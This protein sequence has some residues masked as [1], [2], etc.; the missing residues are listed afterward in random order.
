MTNINHNKYEDLMQDEYD[1]DDDDEG[2]EGE[3]HLKS[4]KDEPDE[5]REDDAKPKEEDVSKEA[6]GIHKRDASRG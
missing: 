5:E 6:E 1:D 4:G 3:R 2:D